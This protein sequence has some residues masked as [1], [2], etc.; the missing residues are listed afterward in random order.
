MMKFNRKKFFKLATPI[1]ERSRGAGLLQSQVDNLNRL[2]DFIERDSRFAKFS[3]R[4]AVRIIAYFLAT[5]QLEAKTKMTINGKRVFVS[6]FAPIREMG[7]DGYLNR[8]YDTGRKARILGNTL[9]ADGDGARFA[10]AGYVQDTGR[11]NAIKLGKRLKGRKIRRSDVQ[12]D[13]LND[14]KVIEAF[15][16][17]SK[18]A[19]SVS[20]DEN[21]FVAEPDLRLVP[22]VSYESAIDGMLTGRFTGRKITDYVSES[23]ND[24]YNARRVING[25][26][27]AVAEEIAENARKFET[28]LI[29]SAEEMVSVNPKEPDSIRVPAPASDLPPVVAASEPKK[30]DDDFFGSYIDKRV[31]PE[32]AEEVAKTVGKPLWSRILTWLGVLYAALE[33]GNV[34]A[35]LGA[36]VLVVGLVL[37]IYL[38]REPIKRVLSRVKTKIVG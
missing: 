11:A 14:L 18:G 25:V 1:I 17:L 29:E 6:N 28:A 34:Y 37:F 10:G 23:R 32:N 12:G 33:A 7:G 3:K 9:D 8:M 24:Y 21:T 31:T 38:M 30:N 35:W 22:W 19:D 16:R 13:S 2:L 36:A 4:V 26:V 27:P 15:N 5:V 20:I